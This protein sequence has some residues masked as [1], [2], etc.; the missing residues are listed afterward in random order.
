MPAPGRRAAGRLLREPAPRSRGHRPE[1]LPV[2]TLTAPLHVAEAGKGREVE[3]QNEGA[4]PCGV[5]EESTL[6]RR[7][8]FTVL[9]PHGMPFGV[10][11][12]DGME[13]RIGDVEQLLTFRGDR[14]G[15]MSLGM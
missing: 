13:R 7:R 4:G 5:V 1:R 10:L 8:L 14:D 9:V 3:R 6:A 2:P 11:E 12:V 15:D